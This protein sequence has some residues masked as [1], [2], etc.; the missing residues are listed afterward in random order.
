MRYNKKI[1]KKFGIHLDRP[2]GYRDEFTVSKYSRMNYCRYRYRKGILVIS[3]QC[4]Q[5]GEKRRKEKCLPRREHMLKAE[6]LYV[7]YPHVS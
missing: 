4:N 7:R 6:E 5:M 2:K 3:H 1:L